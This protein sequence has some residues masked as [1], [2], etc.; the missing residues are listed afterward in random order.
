MPSPP[1]MNVENGKR[2]D[3]IAGSRLRGPFMERHRHRNSSTEVRVVVYSHDTMGVGHMRR[4]LLIAAAL[5]KRFANVNILAIAGAREACGF[6]QQAGI[7][8]LTLPAFHKMAD[9]R[10]TSRSLEIA[11]HDVLE[12]RSKTILAA[13]Q[14]FCPQLMIVDK[15]PAGAG[16][17]LLPALEW[18]TRSGNGQ[19]VLGLREILDQPEIV[20]REWAASDMFSVIREYYTDVWVYG[21]PVV[22]D[23]RVEYR[24]P[25]DIGQ[26]TV[27]TG[28]LDPSLRLEHF[29]IEGDSNESPPILCTV[30]GGQDGQLLLRVFAEAMRDSN[31]RCILLCG[32]HATVTTRLELKRSIGDHDHF[33]VID[34]APEGDLL[35]R[36]AS[37]VVAMG[38]YNTICAILSFRK[39][40]LIVPRTQPRKEQLIRASRLA[41]LGW[42]DMIHPDELDSQSIRTWIDSSQG[43]P[44][45]GPNR[46]PIDLNGLDRIAER[47][48]ALLPLAQPGIRSGVPHVH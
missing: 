2:T 3:S 36:Q 28:Y 26:K 5:R 42:I 24:F 30:G 38:G 37:H 19:C 15:V 4:N 40:A 16:G 13:V 35:I 18:L 33:E 44:H 6:S 22:Y 47:F 46:Q 48:Q 32:P 31:R 9:G 20:Q 29:S 27:F 41:K 39:P 14:S 8:C 45:P 21:D 12:V 43:R 23:T 10:Y 1:L 34:F 7:D 11:S 17:E 25:R